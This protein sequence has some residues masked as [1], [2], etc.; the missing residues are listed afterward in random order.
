MKILITESQVKN[1]LDKYLNNI[2]KSPKFN[3]VDHIDVIE[4]TTKIGNWRNEH[5]APLYEY[6]ICVNDDNHSLS[7]LYE[8]IGDTHA[9]LFPQKKDG[10]PGAY[11][12]VSHKY[13]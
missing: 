4:G 1:I 2:I 5:I 9:L 6:I 11:Y 3:F 12:H 7:D 13:V 8:K 10:S